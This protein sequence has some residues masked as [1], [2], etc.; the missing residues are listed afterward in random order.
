MVEVTHVMQ[1]R[2]LLCVGEEVALVAAAVQDAVGLAEV[3]LGEHA[4]QRPVAQLRRGRRGHLK[5][6][7]RGRRYSTERLAR[8]PPNLLPPV[9]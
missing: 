6:R 8:H 5:E 2:D 7:K 3:G 4:R 9:P 1:Q